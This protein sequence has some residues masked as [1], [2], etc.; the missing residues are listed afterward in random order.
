M[1]LDEVTL[2][3]PEN[4]LGSRAIVKIA[5][6]KGIDVRVSPQ[7]W[8]ARLGRESEATFADLKAWVVVVEMPD[9]DREEA[10]R[11]AGHKVVVLDHHAYGEL[12]RRQPHS[13]LEQLCD[14]VGHEMDDRLWRIALNDREFIPGLARLGIPYDQMEELRREEREILGI[15]EKDFADAL[16]HVRGHRRR[17]G[18]ELDLIVAPYR[19]RHAMAEAAQWP[20]EAEYKQAVDTRQPLPLPNCLILYE[21]EHADAHRLR[22]VE[23]VGS[24]IHRDDLDTVRKEFAAD[25]TLW[26]GGS[27]NHLFWGAEP[28]HAGANVDGLIDTLLSFL[29]IDERPLAHFETT[30]L[31]PFA[32]DGDPPNPAV[33]E[34]ALTDDD[35]AEYLYFHP[36][37][38]QVLYRD[39]TPGQDVE[40]PQRWSICLDRGSRLSLT[41]GWGKGDREIGLEIRDLSLYRFAN[42]GI[43]ILTVSARFAADRDLWGEGGPFWRSLLTARAADSTADHRAPFTLAD[44][45]RFNLL[46]RC[47]YRSFIAQPDEGKIAEVR[48]D[49]PNGGAAVAFDG[50]GQRFDLSQARQPAK[51]LSKVVRAMVAAFFNSESLPPFDALLDDRMFVHSCFALPGPQPRHKGGEARYEA[52]YSR[53]LYV[54][55]DGW[56]SLGGFC[57]DPKFIRQQMKGCT[58]RRWYA[59]SGNLYGFTR[60]SAVYMGFGTYFQDEIVHHVATLYLR[61][62]LTA[63][64]YRA[65]LLEY[66][67]KVAKT[68]ECLTT[69]NSR[70]GHERERKTFAELRRKWIQFT[71]QLWFPELTNQDQGIEIFDLQTKALRL[72]EEYDT[73]KEELERADDYVEMEG[74]RQLN[75]LGTLFGKLGLVFAIL[76]LLTGFF[77]MNFTAIQTWGRSATLFVTVFLTCV[78]LGWLALLLWNDAMNQWR[79]GGWPQGLVAKL[80]KVWA[81]IREL[82][83]NLRGG[84]A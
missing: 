68:T 82:H 36:H 58:Y 33:A 79:D 49:P 47:L 15:T 35:T 50:R 75:R 38:R 14:L 13:S 39:A 76:A 44:G 31:F 29:L 6:D 81:Y 59:L 56:S 80:K 54:D 4:D 28:R 11:Q 21:E 70:A 48:W 77:G 23:Y 65:A 2:I 41:T 64:F 60:Y 74:D 32:F 53:G 7:P 40:A 73:V 10:L 20:E 78:G 1:R 3:C 16:A 83:K 69:G 63:L 17:F 30:F 18:G 51:R 22:Q 42:P 8:G 45:L 66:A 25:F 24:A 67:R 37:L 43:H 61:L 26:S 52:A 9:P 55:V 62:T 5:R 72:Q 34:R 84:E 46:G 19:L 57:Y 71:N 12:D 27:A